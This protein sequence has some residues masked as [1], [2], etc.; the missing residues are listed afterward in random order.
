MGEEMC[1][2]RGAVAVTEEGGTTG[3]E[4]PYDSRW[5]DEEE[6]ETGV[7]NLTERESYEKRYGS[8]S[9]R[10]KLKVGK[11]GRGTDT[12]LLKEA[13]WSQTRR[14]DEMLFVPQ[15]LTRLKWWLYYH[16][17]GDICARTH[18]HTHNFWKVLIGKCFISED[19]HP[20]CMFIIATHHLSFSLNSSPSLYLS[21][22]L[23]V[24]IEGSLTGGSVD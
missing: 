1:R 11:I 5:G 8:Q 18:I 20:Q 13:R 6:W 9:E 7:E 14:K 10:E 4:P 17:T 21:S 15:L 24:C 23:S 22:S 16:L 19:K 12:G 3:L 2:E